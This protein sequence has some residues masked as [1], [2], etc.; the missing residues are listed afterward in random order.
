MTT[1]SSLRSPPQID[2]SNTHIS[3]VLLPTTDPN[4]KPNHRSTRPTSCL[5]FHDE[6]NLPNQTS[7]N[8][9]WTETVS[10]FTIPV[11]RG[12]PAETSAA[13][14][15]HTSSGRAPNPMHLAFLI[16]KELLCLHWRWLI[17]S[18]PLAPRPAELRPKVP[19][20]LLDWGGRKLF[21]AGQRDI[22][23]DLSKGHGFKLIGI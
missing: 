5:Y 10:I 11:I 8:W 6:S 21:G 22:Y 3:P 13:L 19:E 1:T 7:P 18:D 14:I 23:M 2:L 17:D 4:E 15:A 12:S 16:G 9:P 20:I